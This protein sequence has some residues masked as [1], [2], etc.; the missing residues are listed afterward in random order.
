MLSLS[1]LLLIA[2]FAQGSQNFYEQ[3]LH[4]TKQKN[5]NA[6]YIRARI[7]EELLE[8]EQGKIYQQKNTELC[9]CLN[10]RG[11]WRGSECDTYEE[12]CKNALTNVQK[13]PKFKNEYEYASKTQHYYALKQEGLMSILDAINF[14]NLDQLIKVFDKERY[15]RIVNNDENKTEEQYIINAINLNTDFINSISDTAHPTDLWWSVDVTKE[16]ER[17]NNKLRS[18]VHKVEI[19]KQQKNLKRIE[20]AIPAYQ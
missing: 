9:Y 20:A 16:R 19:A 3:K 1:S 12:A 15:L 4:K 2:G 7:F 6:Y 5:Q 11:E 17:A 8:T 18:L 13:L 10:T 14:Y